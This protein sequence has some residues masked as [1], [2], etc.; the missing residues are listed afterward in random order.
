MTL[1]GSCLTCLTYMHAYV[2]KQKLN[3]II[4]SLFH[5]ELVMGQFFFFQV[6]NIM[7]KSFNKC[8]EVSSWWCMFNAWKSFW[9]LEDCTISY[10]IHSANKMTYYKSYVILTFNNVCNCIILIVCTL[11]ASLATFTYV[12]SIVMIWSLKSER[13]SAYET[14]YWLETVQSFTNSQNDYL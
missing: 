10:I 1:K 6:L 5:C 8:C 2:L 4:S 11:D 12:L 7:K 9:P 14:F 3:S 13:P